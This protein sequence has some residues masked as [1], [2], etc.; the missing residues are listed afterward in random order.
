M[1][2]LGQLANTFWQLFFR[3]PTS[4]SWSN[5]VEATATATNGGLVLAS[6][7][8]PALVV[9]VRPSLNLTFT[10]LISTSDAARS[11]SDG[12]IRQRLAARPSALAAGPNGHMLAL[13]RTKGGSEVMGTTAKLSTWS[14]VVSQATL[15]GLPAGRACGLASLTAVGFLGAGRLAAG[16][17][18]QPGVVGIFWHR[19]GGGWSLAGPKLPP[20]LRGREAQ[21]LGLGGTQTGTWAL[22]GLSS[23]TGAALVACWSQAAGRWAMSAP[24]PVPPGEKLTSY[25]STASGRLYVLLK[26]R[27]GTERL[28]LWRE[29][30]SWQGEVAPPRGT[31]TLAAG[32]SGALDA[33]VPNGKVLAIWALAPG[34]HRWVEAQ[35][36][37]VAIQ[38]GSSS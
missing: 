4:K 37:H 9:G 23:P 20:A 5:K 18:A 31:V 3:A 21:V 24:L 19:G 32:A 33:F 35:T 8:G 7:G 28:S 14:P 1:G 11:W 17:C 15:A 22:V 27:P 38:Y 10:P 29:G 30:R 12:L 34:G 6:S 16:S 13:V 25:G 36:V 2:R 26:G